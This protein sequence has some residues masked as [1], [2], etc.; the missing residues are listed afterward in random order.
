[1]RDN[2]FGAFLRARREAITPA[3]VGLPT[4]PRR[5]T[6]GLRRTELAMLA[7]ISVEYLTRL[8]QGRDRHPSSEVLGALVDA[9]RLSSEE[10][11]QLWL[12]LGTNKPSALCPRVAEPPVRT[13]REGV[14]AILQRLEPSPALVV[15]RIGD[16]LARTDGYQRLAGPVGV[17]D[18]ERPNLVRFVFTDDRART[19]H[20]EWARIADAQVNFL[21]LGFH[22]D[23]PHS[24]GL[25]EEL[26]AAAGAPFTSRFEAQQV[27]PERT[28][29]ERWVHPE[30]GE[31]RLGFEVLE[32]SG[33]DDQ[34]LIIYLP[35]DDSTA[36]ALDRLDGRHPGGLRAVSG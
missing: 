35:A 27:V 13:V 16:V 30:V 34:R 24:A 28:G 15:N 11:A 18:A 20:P 29:V 23:D 3:E 32:V 19:A 4:G 33:T 1:M 5:R 9:L 12:I 26:S 2:E 31:L 7:G 25:V 36:A 6:P 17:L 8:E 22:C 10:R 21:R 14:Q